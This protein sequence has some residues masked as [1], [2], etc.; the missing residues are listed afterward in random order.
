[1]Q[2]RCRSYLVSKARLSHTNISVRCIDQKRRYPFVENVMAH[3]KLQPYV[4]DIR[5][6]V[7][8]GDKYHH[9]VV[10]FKRHHRLPVN[11]AV[12]GLTF[13]LRGDIVVL[14]ASVT[15]NPKYSGWRYVN[16]RARDH[17]LADFAMEE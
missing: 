9:F 11:L 7:R 12:P 16:M 15:M 6:A 10:F 2:L 1:V 3:A 17:K 14:R 5:I 8:E 4:H 13:Q